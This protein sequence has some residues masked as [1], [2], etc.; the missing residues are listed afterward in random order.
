MMIPPAIDPRQLAAEIDASVAE[1][2][3]L[4]NL[5]SQ[6]GLKVE[7]EVHEQPMPDR[8]CA[9]PVVAVQVVAPL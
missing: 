2:N 7:L 9:C 1:L 3:R 8:I 5:A 6:L 4:A